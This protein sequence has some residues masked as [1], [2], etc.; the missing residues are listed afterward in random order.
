[1]STKNI[2]AIIGLGNP[3]VRFVN[4]R[5]NIGFMVLDGL[6]DKYNVSWQTKGNLEYAEIETDTGKNVLLIKP[7]TYMNDSGKVIP[8]LKSK[9]INVDNLLVVHDELESS[10]GKVSIK[11]GGSARGHNGLRSIIEFIGPDFERVR[12]GIGRP[13]Q[14][15]M[16]ADYVLE[17]FLDIA[18]ADE[19]VQMA[20]GVIEKIIA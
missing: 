3:G 19:M 20:I 16:V 13:E 6:A 8:F 10:L 4:T 7:L 14:P 18:Q 15:E 12:C 1:M 17:R 9:N 2:K 5:H 11:E